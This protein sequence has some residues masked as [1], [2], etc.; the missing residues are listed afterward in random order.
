MF[1]LLLFS[2]LPR[3]AS[4]QEHQFTVSFENMPLSNALRHIAEEFSISLVYSTDLVAP[5]MVDCAI[6]NQSLEELL[7]CVLQQ[8]NLD[9]TQ[10]PSGT[11]VI[12][13]SPETKTLYGYF[14]GTVF[15]QERG[16]PIPDTHV[17]LSSDQGTLGSVTNNAGQFIFPKLEAG[18]YAVSTSHLSYKSWKDS[19]TVVPELYTNSDIPLRPEPFLI[20][21]IVID[22][23]QHRLSPGQLDHEEIRADNQELGRSSRNPVALFRQ[24]ESLVGV[25]AS[26]ATADIHL[27]G[28]QAGAHQLRLN[29]APVFLPRNAVGFISPISTFALSKLTVHKAGFGVNLGSQTAGVIQGEY[30]LDRVNRIAAQLDQHNLNLRLQ[31]YASLNGKGSITFMLSLRQSIWDVYPPKELKN[32]LSNW[33]EPDFFQVVAPSQLFIFATEDILT[34]DPSQL[35]P[36][37]SLNY[38]GFHGAIRARLN[39]NETITATYYTGRTELDS[40]NTQFVTAPPLSARLTSRD[41]YTWRYNVGQVRYNNL[42]SGKALF[43]GQFRYSETTIDHRYGISAGFLAS[44]SEPIASPIPWLDFTGDNIEDSN[45]ISELGTMVSLEFPFR[46]HHVQ[47]GVEG[48]FTQSMHRVPLFRI[49]EQ[50][51]AVNPD[52]IFVDPYINLNKV[53][54]ERLAFFAQDEISLGDNWEANLGVR[55][56]L[57]HHSLY[58]EPRLSI[59]Y[60]HVNSND[61]ALSFKTSIGMYRQFVSQIDI[62]TLNSFKLLPTT[63]IWFPF[64][65]TITPPRTT[66][67]SQAVAWTPRASWTFRIEGYVN[68]QG[69]ELAMNYDIPLSLDSFDSRVYDNNDDGFQESLPEEFPVLELQQQDFLTEVISRNHGMN[70]VVGWYKQK[71][72]AELQ[73]SYSHATRKGPGLFAGQVHEV[74]WNEP[75]KSII[76]FTYK[77]MPSF[78]ATLRTKSKWGRSWGLQ[79]AYYDYFGSRESTRYRINYDFG[80]PSEHVLPPFHQLDI[81][82]AYTHKLERT[83]FQ[84]RVDVLNA[85]DRSNVIDWRLVYDLIS[86]SLNEKPRYAHGAMPVFAIGVRF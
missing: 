23:L 20:S 54:T 12:K 86:N 11:Y 72:N 58:S 40:G 24:A 18:R 39:A 71:F 2:G 70:A 60:D 78:S 46:A 37:L 74:P 75:H 38:A 83:E 56:T 30:I 28:A 79:R 45:R 69:K 10:L 62:S 73:Y 81:S 41:Q 76:Q 22:G 47:V 66:L 19:I 17:L 29:G 5:Y 4:S 67:I 64:D 63:R 49:I 53:A 55:T 44:E 1:I 35:R 52:A 26:D 36:D 27:Q 6:V 32:T 9:F 43:S 59:R 85:L 33:T 51:S 50:A 80:S 13:K 15:D 16:I 42:I 61:Q 21:P 77:P 48:T 68:L 65:H 82:V 7:R 8:S 34:Q 3:E 57:F 31:R 14:A 84:F 25:S